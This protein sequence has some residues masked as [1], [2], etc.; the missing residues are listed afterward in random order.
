MSPRL[1]WFDGGTGFEPAAVLIFL[2]PARKSVVAR[3][4]ALHMD[5]VAH[6]LSAMRLT[7]GGHFV[8]N[9]RAFDRAEDAQAHFARMLSKS[10]S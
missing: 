10:T 8:V 6:A 3:G 2:D 9:G 7:G 1:Q 5:D 4:C